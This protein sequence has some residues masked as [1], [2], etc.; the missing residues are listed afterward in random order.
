MMSSKPSELYSKI[1]YSV[2]LF[3]IET[4]PNSLRGE[5]ATYG[6]VTEPSGITPITWKMSYINM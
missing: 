1:A 6:V 4:V 5:V 2:P 3:L